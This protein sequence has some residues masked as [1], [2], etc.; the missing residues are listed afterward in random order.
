MTDHKDLYRRYIGALIIKDG[1]ALDSALDQVLAV[2]FVAHDLPGGL[3]DGRGALKAFR[4]QV[5]IAF[6]DQTLT[7]EDLIAEDGRVAARLTAIGTHLGKFRGIPATGRK[8]TAELFDIVRVAEEKIAERWTMFDR[9]GL[10][11]EL[12]RR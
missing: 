4:R 2:D 1:E 5:H 12:Q 6:P 10:L 8:I 7:I 9:G 3:V 11:T